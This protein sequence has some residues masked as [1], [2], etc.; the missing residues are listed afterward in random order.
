MCTE[1]AGTWLSPCEAVTEQETKQKHRALFFPILSSRRRE[2]NCTPRHT[3]GRREEGN[4]SGAAAPLPPS[5]LIFNKDR[6]GVFLAP[7]SLEGGRRR[8]RQGEREGGR[9]AD[10]TAQP[11]NENSFGKRKG[12]NLTTIG[13]RSIPPSPH[14]TGGKG[15]GKRS[16]PPPPPKERR[17]EKREYAA[18]AAA[19][20]AKT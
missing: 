19:E 18:A 8:R 4:Y 6:I 17:K 14:V 12:R 15:G 1:K 7:V 20:D 2:L 13:H 11:E 16:V 10:F 3:R 5:P 9:K